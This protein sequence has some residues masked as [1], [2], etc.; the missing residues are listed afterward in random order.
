MEY[1]NGK[2]KR[3]KT[4]VVSVQHNKDK[5]LD[6]LKNE[7]ISEILHPVSECPFDADTEILVNPSGR[8]VEGG[9][10]ADTSSRA[11]S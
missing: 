2:P 6:V 10:G 8:F 9:P 4:I 3:V 5:D 7:I 11:E 1:V